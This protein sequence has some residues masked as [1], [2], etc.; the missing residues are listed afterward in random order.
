M[1][2]DLKQKIKDAGL[3]LWQV[4]DE[5]GICEMTLIRWLRKEPTEEQKQRIFVAIKR[6]KEGEQA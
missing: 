4:A 5:I 1:G 6:L 2:K 3:Y